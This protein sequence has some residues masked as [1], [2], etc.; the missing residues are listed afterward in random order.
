MQRTKATGG[1]M[2]RKILINTG[3]CGTFVSAEVKQLNQKAAKDMPR[4]LFFV[5][6]DDPLLISIVEQVGLKRAGRA[7]TS[8]KI[9]E[10]P[11]DVDWEIVDDDG[12][13]LVGEKRRRTW[14]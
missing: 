14:G 3:C 7:L 11:D 13:E 12:A 1:S 4:S 8:F 5:Q 9:V 6:R 2:P 10:I